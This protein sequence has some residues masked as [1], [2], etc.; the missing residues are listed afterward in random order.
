MKLLKLIYSLDTSVNHFVCLLTSTSMIL[1][2]DLNGALILEINPSHKIVKF[3]TNPWTDGN[4]TIKHLFINIYI[5][6]FIATLGTDGTIHF[7]QI[8]IE[9][10]PASQ[11]NS[12]NAN[13]NVD[14]QRQGAKFNYRYSAKLIYIYDISQHRLLDSQEQESISSRD[15]SQ[16]FSLYD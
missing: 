16:V 9:R 1:I 14:P 7:F 15:F 10:V 5:E 3:T 4:F 11:L 12:N 8:E 2:Y 6:F 13:A